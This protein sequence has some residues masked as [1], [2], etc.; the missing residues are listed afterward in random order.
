MPSDRR[1]R[2]RL[3]TRRAISFVATASS[4]SGASIM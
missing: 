2:K 4:A 1:S 3:A